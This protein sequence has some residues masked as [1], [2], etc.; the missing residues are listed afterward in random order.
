[1]GFTKEQQNNALQDI[2]VYNKQ[3]FSNRNA[4]PQASAMFSTTT[5]AAPPSG[6]DMPLSCQN[7]RKL[8][9][10][11]GA[12]FRTADGTCN[13]LRHNLWGS[14]LIPM[15]R[16]LAPAYQDGISE[17]RILGRNGG[18]LTS[19]RDIS[20]MLHPTGPN[21]QMT[22]LTHMVMQWGQFID[23]DL[24]STPVQTAHDGSALTCCEDEAPRNARGQIDYNN[25]TSCF[26]IPIGSR[27]PFFRGRTCFSFPRSVQVT[28]SNCQ[29]GKLKT[30]SRDLLPKDQEET[31]VVHNPAT[32]YCFKAGD[33][34]VNEQM[35]LASMHTVWLRQHNR[36]VEQLALINPH[37]DDERLFQ[38]ARKIVGA[39]IQ[40]VTYGEWLPIVLD[41]GR[42]ARNDLNLLGRGRQGSLY[43]PEVDASIRN[44]FG[45]A[46]FRFGHS[47]IRDTMSQLTHNY[48]DAGSWRLEQIFGNTSQILSSQGLGV[49]MYMRGLVRDPPNMVDRFFTAE[50]RNHLF[51]DGTGNS[52]DLIA[53][54]IQ[55]GRDHGLPPYN[56]WRRYCGLRP[57]TSFNNMPD[58]EFG[59]GQAFS[60]VYQHPD[61]IDIFSGGISELREGGGLVGPTFACLIAEQFRNVKI[62]D[63][64]WYETS[65]RNTGFTRAQLE[66]IRRHSLSRILCDVTAITQIQPNPFRQVSIANSLTQCQDLPEMN[67]MEWAE[68]PRRIVDP[69]WGMWGKWSQ[70]Q[71]GVQMRYSNPCPG[72]PEESRVCTS[73]MNK[74]KPGGPVWSPWGSW[75]AMCVRGKQWRQRVCGKNGAE[76]SLERSALVQGSGRIRGK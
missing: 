41:P 65:D 43:D 10:D 26:P 49:D 25:R 72:S 6:S 22:S 61:D 14:S 30:S 76:C 63:R 70:C 1:M 42:M 35:A 9:C 18:P 58:Q 29:Q 56:A 48:M 32:D 27:D 54:N 64:F 15:R 24:T 5:T 39:L 13:N 8:Q 33:I 60:M 46:A 52:L 2:I 37:W 50:V 21:G 17:P 73:T 53:F 74:P 11:A 44:V 62:G 47:L 69:Q 55:R 20:N 68:G 3:G 7:S 16:I 31:C 28:N 12:R 75:N 51:Q 57:V 40:Q 38:E 66:E 36:L 59:T 71:Q 34:R 23:H 67:L 4:P 45:T 19:A